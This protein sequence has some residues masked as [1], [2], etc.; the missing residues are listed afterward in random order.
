LLIAGC[1]DLGLRLADRL[2]R[3]TADERQP[4]WQVTGLR[5]SIEGLPEPLPPGLTPVAADLADPATLREL[6]G[7]WDAIIYTAT[8]GARDEAAYRGIYIDG[9]RHLLDHARAQ[10]LIFVSSTAVY[11]QDEGEWVDEDAET[12]PRRFNGE[13]LLQAES[14]ARAAGG[15]VLRFSGIYGPGREALLN[16]VRSGGLRCRREPPIWTNR[17]HSE[18]CAAALEHLLDL[19]DPDEVY[20]A[21][22]DAPAPRWEVLSWLAER[23]GAPA[24]EPDPDDAGGQGKRVSAT[25][26]K[27]SGFTLQYPD[28]RAGYEALLG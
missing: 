23:L 12:V 17:I 10:R 11:G 8:P 14:I 4:N 24:P 7:D 18:D 16:R 6:H 28:Y 27:A 2:A 19:P 21:S 22:D 15:I 1:G 25:R 13:V 20:L 26:L 5:R 9:L 3:R